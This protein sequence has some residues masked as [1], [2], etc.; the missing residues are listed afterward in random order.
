MM[1]RRLIGPFVLLGA[2]AL[3]AVALGA[4]PTATTGA[5]TNIGSTTATL[6]GEV[7]PGRETTTWFFEYGTTTSYGSVTPTDT[8]NGGNATRNVDAAVTG[9]APSTTYHYRLVAQNPSGTVRGAD[10][11]FTTT[12]SG[13]PPT[14]QQDV[15]LAAAP[16][17]VVFGRR[18]V[19]SGRVRAPG[20]DP[21]QVALFA[22]P[23]PLDNSFSQVAAGATAS[24]G[25]Y[26]F[27]HVP[28]VHTRYRVAAATSP[29]TAS[30]DLL[31]RVRIRVTLRLSDRTPR[32]GQRVRF[33]GLAFPAHDGRRVLIQRRGSTGG[34]RTV[35]RTTLR[36][37]GSSRS[38][39]SRSLR[40]SRDGVYRARVSGDADHLTGFSP[41]RTA[42]VGG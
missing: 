13:G 8:I 12:A 11:T 41:S 14:G 34:F 7:N 2:L 16:N 31:V 35:A 28:R 20:N 33:S 17:P 24:N 10:R 4:A 42:N 5:A 27:N 40:V 3:A 19:L 22:D 15:T 39:F 38:R 29:A 23:F 36:D 25:S 21:V 30:P 32:R 9:L 18:V 26:A 1:I 37:A 6:T